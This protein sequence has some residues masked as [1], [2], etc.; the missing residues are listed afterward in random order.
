[1]NQRKMTVIRGARLLDAPSHEANFA[2]ILIEE[3]RIN[4]VGPPGLEAPV[5]AEVVEA[6]DMLLM[7]GLVNAHSHSHGSLAKGMADR[8][9]LELLLNAAP[10]LSGERTLEERYLATLLNA[11]ELVQKGCTAVYDL[12]S[13]FPVP[14]VEG[15][16]AVC[17]A[18]EEVGI[19]AVVAPMMADRL[20]FEAI[21]GLLDAIP[22]PLQRDLDRIRAAP[23][24]ASIESSEK[25]LRGWSRDRSKIRLALAPTIPLHCSDEFL[26]ACRDLARDYGVGLHM[27]LAE[28][29]VQVVSGLRKYGKTLTAHLDE[30]EFITPGFVGAHCVWLDDEDLLRMADNGASIAHNPGSN[31]RLGSG[32]APARAMLQRGIHVGIGTDG[33]VCSDNQNMFEAMRQTSF[34]S[35][36]Q[37][38]DY[39]TWLSTEE[40]IHLATAGSARVLG[41]EN[42]IGRILPGYRA[43]FVFLDLT[44]ISYVPF[45]DATNQV[46]NCED[47][48]GVRSVMVDGRMIFRDGEFTQL[49]YRKMVRDV[50]KVADRLKGATAQNKALALKLEK[51]VGEYCVGLAREPYH[52]HRML[53][54]S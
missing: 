34:V 22:T 41:F 50:E 18:Y 2:D 45:N 17:R 48:S 3:G 47:G 9:S 43:D 1:M 52:V 36:V 54:D 33:S 4:E 42:E 20:L 37:S 26:I 13:E 32:I 16:E 21:P 53:P 31:L 25:L 10:W 24:E 15:L 14:T 46:V 38:P 19:R 27:H 28:S 30:L 5:E 7:P 12:Y 39:S 40:I 23:Y 6:T 49:D 35:R 29:K 8:F 44:T 11:V 51:Y